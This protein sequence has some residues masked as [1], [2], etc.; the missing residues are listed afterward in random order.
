MA[1]KYSLRIGFQKANDG[2]RE[3]IVVM[4]TQQQEAGEIPFIPLSPLS[5]LFCTDISPH[6]KVELSQLSA[7]L[8][9]V[10]RSANPYLCP[11]LGVRAHQAEAKI[12]SHMIIVLPKFD[13]GGAAF[14]ILKFICLRAEK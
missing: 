9:Q 2:A 11:N 4:L 10:L 13:G 7:M 14:S 5:Y 6:P 1:R 12:G 3:K 8:C